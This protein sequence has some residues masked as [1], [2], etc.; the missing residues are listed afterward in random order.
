[1]PKRTWI[2][3]AGLLLLV[4]GIVASSRLLPPRSSSLTSPLS[5]HVIVRA[6]DARHAAAVTMEAVSVF[7]APR[8]TFSRL[9]GLSESRRERL[10]D[11]RE[12]P[13]ERFDEPD[14]AVEFYVNSRTGPIETRGPN[15]PIGVRPL[16]P[17]LYLPALEQMRSMPRFDSGSNTQLPPAAV[18]EG[19]DHVLSTRQA[20]R[21]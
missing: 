4:I 13:E 1:M 3:A 10:L 17:S 5:G 18:S 9:A 20:P 14:R 7:P 2:V 19:Q 16:D 8:R 12:H 15:P 21:S 6:G 11:E